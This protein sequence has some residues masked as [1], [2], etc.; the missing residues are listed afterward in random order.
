MDRSRLPPFD[1]E[2]PVLV[3]KIGAYDLH[4]GSLGIVRSL[5]RVGVPVYA[6]LDG[7]L[8]P[9]ALSRHLRGGFVWVTSGDE[10]DLVEQLSRIGR[11]LPRRSILVPTDDE[12]AILVAEHAHVLAEWFR[13]PRQP[14]TLPRSVASK[15]SLYHLCRRL[16][17]PCPEAAFPSSEQDLLGFVERA[18]FPVMLKAVEPWLFGRRTGL[19]STLLLRTPDELVEVFRGLQGRPG[20]RVMLQDYIPRGVAEDWIVHG[21]CDAGSRCRV[22]YTGVK[23]R[24]YPPDAGLTTLGRC[25]ANPSLLAQVQAM[26]E[27]LEY[28]GILDMDWRLDRRD[29][30]YKLLDFNPRVGAQFRLFE[31]EHGLDVVRAMHLDLTAREI[32][33][34]SQPQGRGY[35]VE[36]LDCLAAM[37]QWRHGALTV[38]Q[39]LASL[40]C[41]RECAW[42]AR[43]D[44]L[45]F[46]MLC[47]RF[48]LRG[49]R[50]TVRPRRQ[51]RGPARLRVRLALAAA[52]ARW[53]SH[54]RAQ[55]S[56]GGPR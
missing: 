48:A 32:P 47:L 19:R 53:L 25:A 55:R 4:H 10:R 35:V 24:A 26:L 33:T 9:M 41:V 50:R 16:G 44:P 45:P 34:P 5:G 46:V 37:G 6:I 21:Y 20:S 8:A 18:S 43:D 23:L 27:R 11:R 49:A 13:F 12:A 2:T 17:V 39:W 15:Q 7:R 42:F 51:Q 52:A 3:L 31:D 56:G 28:R 36:H 29:G 30:Q 22:A 54:G 1:V 40:R 14:S 38:R